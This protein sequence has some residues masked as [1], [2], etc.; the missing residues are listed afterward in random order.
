VMHG[1]S[2]AKERGLSDRHRQVLEIGSGISPEVIEARGYWTAEGVSELKATSDIAPNQYHAPA[3][4][5][6]VF[7]VD[8]EYRYSRVRPD[9]PPENM[10]K[11][12]QPAGT[13]NVLDVPR[14]VL[15]KV[16]D[17]K[18]GLVLTEG[19]RKADSLASLGI[20]VVC[21]FGVWNWSCKTDK[22]TPYEM[23]LLLPDF[24]HIPLRDRRV[25]VVF[26]SDLSSNRSV[27]LAA[28]RL[29]QRLRERGAQVW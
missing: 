14:P 11:Y 20:P 4:V 18:F 9:N 1:L 17:P 15:D 7:G 23:Q 3:L 5:L 26:D 12:I 6:P 10:G 8:G 13:P 27:Q 19:E 21:L 22:D 29:V 16:L 24:D 25:G 28:K 2:A